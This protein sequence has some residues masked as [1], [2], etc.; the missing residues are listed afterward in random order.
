MLILLIII[1]LILIRLDTSNSYNF[2]EDIQLVIPFPSGIVIDKVIV[3]DTLCRIGRLQY[4][5]VNLR[6]QWS[7]LYIYESL[8]SIPIVDDIILKL[9]RY[10]NINGYNKNR[11]ID[12]NVRPTQD[13]QLEQ[14]YNNDDD[15][16]R[17]LLS[18]IYDILHE[19]LYPTIIDAYQLHTTTNND[20]NSNNKLILSDLFITKYDTDSNDQFS[21]LDA[22]K[23]KTQFSFI[24][25]LNNDDDYEGGGTY[26]YNKQK[27]I[28]L[29][30][31]GDAVFFNGNQY[32]AVLLSL[33]SSLLS[34]PLLLG[35]QSNKR[36][37]NH[38]SW[39]FRLL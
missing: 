29:K 36:D 2:K 27:V 6:P 14:I 31:K 19:N 22:H 32:H 23:D 1:S 13:V 5:T 4:N 35:Y 12:Y 17:Q 8:L 20:N 24:I 25:A 39:F 7:S 26:F 18:N 34:S 33:T 30:K 38:I 15:D 9:N 11:H 10:V 3:N 16:N 28:R 21:F 37:E